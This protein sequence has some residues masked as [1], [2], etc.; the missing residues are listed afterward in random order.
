[1]RRQ[2]S[3]A[4]IRGQGIGLNFHLNLRTF[5]TVSTYTSFYFQEGRVKICTVMTAK[6][7][8]AID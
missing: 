1:M 2:D 8:F 7:S 3:I 6:A 4:A 5:A